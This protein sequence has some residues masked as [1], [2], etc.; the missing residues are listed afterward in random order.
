V[1]PSATVVN[2]PLPIAV[3]QERA[4]IEN[5][6]ASRFYPDT[7]VVLR[8]VTLRLYITRLH[9]EHVNRFTI[10]PFVTSTAFF[11]PQTMGIIEFTPDRAGEFHIRNEGHG[12]DASL[13]V[14]ESEN[15]LRDRWVRRGLQEFSLIHDFAGSQVAPQR[16]TVYE[17][18]PVKVYNTGLG[19]QDKVSI[20]PFYQPTAT[21]VEQGKITVFE[22]TPTIT[23]EFPINYETHKLS[24]VLVVRG[25]P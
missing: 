7:F 13:V 16:L 11:P 24:G 25:R 20:P 17:G 2:T 1:T 6:T 15:E 12:F 18:V 8:G 14:V 22:F 23:G 9:I 19:G 3:S 4:E 5:Y 10:E 21:N